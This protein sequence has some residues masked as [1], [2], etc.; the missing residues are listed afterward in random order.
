MSAAAAD[1]DV[2]GLIDD[3]DVPVALLQVLA[4]IALLLEGIDGDDRLVEVVEGVGVGGDILADALDAGAVEAGERDG[5]ARPQLLLELGHH[6]LG[7]DDQDALAF[8]TADQFRQQNADLDRFAEPDGISEQDALP[9]LAEGLD[10]WVKLVWEGVGGGAV[11]DPQVCV[12]GR[13]LAEEAFE[14]EAGVAEARGVVCDEFLG[15]ERFDVIDLG[16]AAGFAASDEFGDS[17]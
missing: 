5:E 4:E 12:S 17:C 10:R 14:V 1:G 16:Q 6:A 8:A 3:D 2:V 15:M 11:A 7:R 13:R 9:D